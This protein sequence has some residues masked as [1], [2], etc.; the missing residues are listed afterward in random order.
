MAGLLTVTGTALTTGDMI[1]LA[2]PDEHFMHC[3]R[4]T[5]PGKVNGIIFTFTSLTSELSFLNKVFIV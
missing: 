4:S 2:A 3:P 5:T 1:S